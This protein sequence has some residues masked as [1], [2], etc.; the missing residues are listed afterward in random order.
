M[1]MMTPLHQIL[2]WVT[3]LF[4]K[5]QGEGEKVTTLQNSPQSYINKGG[6]KPRMGFAPMCH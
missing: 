2:T 3:L 1:A 4:Q 6:E 5:H